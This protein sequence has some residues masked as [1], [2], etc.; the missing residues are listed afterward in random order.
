M[1]LIADPLH[2]VHHIARTLHNPPSRTRVLPRGDTIQQHN[3]P[4]EVERT[5]DHDGV[6]VRWARA[7]HVVWVEAP[8]VGESREEDGVGGE[9]GGVGRH[10]IGEGEV[11]EG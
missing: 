10:E 2:H 6:H 5:E 4:I 3:T 9:V 7:D 1:H 11:W 8:G